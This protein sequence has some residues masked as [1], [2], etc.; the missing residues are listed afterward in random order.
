MAEHGEQALQ[1]VERQAFDVILMDM[2]MPVMDGYTA[3]RE[4]RR[5]G[6]NRPIIA[7]TAH[8]MNG[9]REKCEAVGCDGY[10]SKP[11][12]MDNVIRTVRAA[13]DGSRQGEV[14]YTS[15]CGELPSTIAV[16][17]P[18]IRSTLPVADPEI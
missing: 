5:R 18:A 7:V 1:V 10:L 12:E 15:G 16:S 8:A 9:D 11:V 13:I 17:I 4:L 14:S 3:A 2:Q 6:F